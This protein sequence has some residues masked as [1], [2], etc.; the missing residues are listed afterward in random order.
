MKVNKINKTLSEL[1]DLNLTIIRIKKGDP[2]SAKPL[3]HSLRG[4]F[5]VIVENITVLSKIYETGYVNN[6]SYIM[7]FLFP[8]MV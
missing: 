6:E 8:V 5:L 1:K 4:K 7:G 2:C 3:L